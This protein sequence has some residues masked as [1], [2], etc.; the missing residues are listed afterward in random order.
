MVFL[1]DP[2]RGKYQ[3]GSQENEWNDCALKPVSSIPESASVTVSSA[4]IKMQIEGK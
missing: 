3:Y 2:V 1:G 4:G